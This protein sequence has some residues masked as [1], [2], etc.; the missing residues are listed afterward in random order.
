M[1]SQKGFN[2]ILPVII[3][4]VVI[5]GL[6]FGLAMYFNTE[7]TPLPAIV[8]IGVANS[9]S[10]STTNTTI[11]T[12]T[13]ANSNTATDETAGWQTYT[14]E[15]YGY[16]VKHPKEWKEKLASDQGV[17]D[18][19]V[20]VIP[21]SPS[22]SNVEL[23]VRITPFTIQE[24]E[25]LEQ[26]YHRT[27]GSDVSSLDWESITVDGVESKYYTGIPSFVS[28]NAALVQKGNLGYEIENHTSRDIFDLVLSTFQFTD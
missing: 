22:G 9:N 25:T 6:V 19:Y 7:E 2:T 23:K 10:N 20:D 18:F 5:G 16:S 17:Y 4:A 3:F 27:T 13:T 15:E 12:N 8:N 11:N 21:S 28:Y 26:A 14:N 24:G 1:T